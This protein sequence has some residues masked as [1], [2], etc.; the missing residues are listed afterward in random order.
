MGGPPGAVRRRAAPGRRR[1][2]PPAGPTGRGPRLR[3][4]HR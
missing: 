4:G 2:G 1:G 3:G